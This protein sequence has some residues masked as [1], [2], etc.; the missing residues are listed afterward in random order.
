MSN[1]PAVI[2][3]DDDGFAEA[4]EAGRHLVVGKLLRFRKGVYI[5]GKDE[6]NLSGAT[7]CAYRIVRCWQ[8][9]DD[10]RLVSTLFASPGNPLPTSAD[11]IEDF[12]DEPGEW[13]LTSCLY[14]REM[15]DGRD[16]TFVTSSY[17]GRRAV[18]DLAGQ[19]RNIRWSRPGALPMVRLDTGSFR[20]KQYGD[21]PSKRFTVLGWVTHDGQPHPAAPV[22]Q[23]PRQDDPTNV[24]PLP[25]RTRTPVN[26]LDDDIPF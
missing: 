15:D 21:V 23:G 24:T 20:S 11:E 12:G 8:K 10:T 22:K 14:L 13:Q 19:S 2:D 7:L 16:Y 17:G 6:G 1:M 3:N 5:V 18:G 4:A 26:D 9:W 25:A